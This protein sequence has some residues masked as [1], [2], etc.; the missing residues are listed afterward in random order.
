MLRTALLT[1]T[2]RLPG[3]RLATGHEVRCMP[4]LHK[5]VRELRVEW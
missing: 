4:G 2:G 5:I 1:L 3:L